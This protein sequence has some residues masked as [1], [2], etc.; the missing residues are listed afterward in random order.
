MP[1]LSLFKPADDTA[2]A[3]VAKDV[4]PQSYDHTFIME[5]LD[6]FGPEPF[7][8]DLHTLPIPSSVKEA[9]AKLIENFCNVH[10][11]INAAIVERDEV[12]Q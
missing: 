5:Q 1:S 12:D 9:T 11:D 8:Q 7:L 4:A 6:K 10:A 2:A 3:S